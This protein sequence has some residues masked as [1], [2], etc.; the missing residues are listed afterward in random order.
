MSSFNEKHRV[1]LLFSDDAVGLRAADLY[2]KYSLSTQ[3]R[4]KNPLEPWDT[5]CGSRIPI[6]GR[7]KCI[8]IPEGDARGDMKFGRIF[9][10]S[11]GYSTSLRARARV[12]D[13]LTGVMDS[14]EEFMAARWRLKGSRTNA[15]RGGAVTS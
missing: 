11:V 7:P 14:R 13:S 6:S 12:L 9:V 1:D 4:R 3:V 2:S 8:Q 10:W 5:L 15:F